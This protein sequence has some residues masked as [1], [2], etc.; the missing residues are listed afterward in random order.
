ME[1]EE[2]FA[3]NA[4]RS[5]KNYS[6][7]LFNFIDQPMSLVIY[8]RIRSNQVTRREVKINSGDPISAV[9]SEPL[10]SKGKT[11]DWALAD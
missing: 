6:K 4:H 8:L 9:R 11:L 1:T 10:A 2:T 5:C 7:L 3:G